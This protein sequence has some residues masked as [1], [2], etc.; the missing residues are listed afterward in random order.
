MTVRAASVSLRQTS[1]WSGLGPQATNDP[2]DINK[3]YW[4]DYPL[5]G[6]AKLVAEKLA[7]VTSVSIEVNTNE[8][9]LLYGAVS[10]SMVSDALKDQGLKVEARA[11]EI[12]EVHNGNHC[13]ILGRFAGKSLERKKPENAGFLVSRYQLSKTAFEFLPHLGLY[14]RGCGIRPSGRSIA[15]CKAAIEQTRDRHGS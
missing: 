15:L 1:V 2:R 9:G 14:L 8:E 12:A 3:D 5:I 6:D 4:V 7:G 13:R 10:P 11:I